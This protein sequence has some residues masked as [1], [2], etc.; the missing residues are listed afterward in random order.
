MLFIIGF[1]LILHINQVIDDK[2][3]CAQG[4]NELTK[5]RPKSSHRLGHVFLLCFFRYESRK[6]MV[7]IMTCDHSLVRNDIKFVYYTM[8]I[9][10]ICYYESQNYILKF[11]YYSMILFLI[12]L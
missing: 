6:L 11:I 3:G 10:L 12:Y 9:F 4:V 1:Q 7:R 8:I 2:L 5:F